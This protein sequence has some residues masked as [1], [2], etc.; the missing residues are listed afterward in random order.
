MEAHGAWT[1]FALQYP[2]CADCATW[3]PCENAYNEM[4]SYVHYL[5]V[6]PWIFWAAQ[7]ILR[8]N[9]VCFTNPTQNWRIFVWNG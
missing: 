3:Q 5:Y 9:S 1:L 7:I 4:A 2:S 8:P 6:R